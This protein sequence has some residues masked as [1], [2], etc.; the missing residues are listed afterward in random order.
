MRAVR[1]VFDQYSSACT[2]KE[3]EGL[4]WEAE[5]T[6]WKELAANA[7]KSSDSSMAK[8]AEAAMLE[9]AEKA[10]KKDCDTLALIT[11]HVD[12]LLQARA[13]KSVQPEALTMAE[14]RARAATKKYRKS[15]EA[16]GMWVRV[17]AR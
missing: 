1:E 11:E 4:V 16:W 7:H 12:V 17:Y 5:F 13:G 6:L 2:S 15:V 10:Q 14:E 8:A 9:C 3:K